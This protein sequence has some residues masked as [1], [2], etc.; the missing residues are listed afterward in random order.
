LLVFFGLFAS[1]QVKTRRIEGWHDL[2][3]TAATAASKESMASQEK[4]MS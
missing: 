3:E 1:G 4:M 2:A